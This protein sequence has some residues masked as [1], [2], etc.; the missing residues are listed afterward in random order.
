MGNWRRPPFER[1]QPQARLAQLQL[2][3]LSDTKHCLCSLLVSNLGPI[4]RCTGSVPSLC[5]GGQLREAAYLG[6]KRGATKEARDR[7]QPLVYHS[8]P[9][10][11]WPGLAAAAANHAPPSARHCLQRLAAGQTDAKQARRRHTHSLASQPA[12][13]SV[14]A[15][16][17]LNLGASVCVCVCD[18]VIQ[19]TLLAA[20]C[21]SCWRSLL[22]AVCCLL[23]LF[24][25]FVVAF[26]WPL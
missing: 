13:L 18:C 10:V 14:C 3:S 22:F 15:V 26:N 12:P 6:A 19:L 5:T 23:L 25:L 1:P 4:S 24:L 8:L 2:A 11:L 17:C 16:V 21:W 9:P 7:L 20:C